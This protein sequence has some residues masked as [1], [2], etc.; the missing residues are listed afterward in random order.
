MKKVVLTKMSAHTGPNMTPM[1]DIVMC[2]LIFFMLASSF[3][4]ADLFLT[5]NMPAI[6][7]KGLGDTKGDTAAPAIQSKIDV[8]M[9]G[10]SGKGQK[11]M[12]RGFGVIIEDL[13]QQLPLTLANK[14][15]EMSPDAQ[16]I[17]VPTEEVP[18]QDVITV[19]D[20]CM[21]ARFKNVAFSAPKK[22]R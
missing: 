2:I 4:A 6:D 8:Y 22:G 12:V 17:I 11:A 18:Y 10:E 19:Y 14:Q 5:S 16:I 7:K 20:A 1:V 15:R 13:E 21:K 3:A 9:V